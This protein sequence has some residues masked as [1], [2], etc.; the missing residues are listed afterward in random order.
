[1][2]QP[3]L[4]KIE[5]PDLNPEAVENVINYLH[6]GQIPDE[7][8]S[9]ELF[10]VASKYVDLNFKNT[11]RK[12]WGQGLTLKNATSR[13]LTFLNCKEKHLDRETSIFLAKNF[14]YVEIHSD[15]KHVFAN[16]EAAAVL[17][18]VIGE[19]F[20]YFFVGKIKN[21]IFCL[22]R[23][24]LILMKS[25]SCLSI[26]LVGS[27]KSIVVSRSNIFKCSIGSPCNHARGKLIIICKI[28]ETSS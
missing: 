14:N 21:N 5:I 25:L 28:N 10:L 23:L 3:D 18:Q 6:T 9:Y 15:C 2:S 8:V 1:M 11:C 4:D 7:N 19:H 20:F 17:F 16:N 26:G 24:L 13:L 27:S 12:G 22:V